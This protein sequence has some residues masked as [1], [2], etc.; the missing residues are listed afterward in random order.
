[1]KLL[2]RRHYS[3]NAA[4]AH[5]ANRLTDMYD[6]RSDLKC[7]SSWV[8]QSNAVTFTVLGVCSQ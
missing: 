2:K 7:I 8:R 5:R 1:M 3:D 4:Y 6:N